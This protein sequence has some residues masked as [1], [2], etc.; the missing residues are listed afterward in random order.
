MRKTRKQAGSGVERRTQP[1]ALRMVLLVL[2][3]GE[4]YDL[5]AMAQD[6]PLTEICEPIYRWILNAWGTCQ[7]QSPPEGGRP[8]G[9]LRLELVFTKIP[10]RQASEEWQLL[11]AEVTD[12]A[13]PIFQGAD[14]EPRP[15]ALP[16]VQGELTFQALPGLGESAAGKES[17]EG[18]RQKTDNKIPV[19][20]KPTRHEEDL[21]LSPEQKDALFAGLPRSREAVANLLSDVAK[22]S[23]SHLKSPGAPPEL[24]EEKGS[25]L[26]KA[27][28]ATLPD[29]YV[30][31]LRVLDDASRVS[32]TELVNAALSA[33]D[34]YLGMHEPQENQGITDPIERRKDLVRQ[35]RELAEEVSG[36]F[37]QLGLTLCCP[38]GKPGSLKVF[39]NEKNTKGQYRLIPRGTGQPEASRANLK[40]LLPSLRFEGAEAH[41]E[42]SVKQAEERPSSTPSGRIR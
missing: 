35:K 40:D 16:F 4:L 39:A 18:R 42:H 32:R 17:L 21:P 14:P 25:P 5:K 24:K 26:V 36:I 7:E 27:V 6:S 37:E 20:D 28:V 22:E 15:I 33:L 2:P 13:L 30:A 38:S 34:A 9:V 11:E 23:V 12:R 19:G 10:R 1:R 31:R 3:T 41:L 8:V 29:D